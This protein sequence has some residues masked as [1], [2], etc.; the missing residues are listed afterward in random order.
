[1]TTHPHPLH[2]L[3]SPIHGGF[4]GPTYRQLRSFAHT[5]IAK[6]PHC[7]ADFALP[8]PAP[9][10]EEEEEVTVQVGRVVVSSAHEPDARGE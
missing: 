1:M 10:E 5:P 4:R 2:R 6:I 7:W 9:S 8:C 3:K